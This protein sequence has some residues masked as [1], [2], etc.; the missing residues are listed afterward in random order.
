MFKKLTVVLCLLFSAAL[1]HAQMTDEAIMTYA[2]QELAAGKSQNQIARDLLAKGV[3][4]AQITRVINNYKAAQA[5]GTLPVTPASL[6]TDRPSRLEPAQE[7]AAPVIASP[8]DVSSAVTDVLPIYGHDIFSSRTMTF[9]PNANMATPENYVLGPGD[10]VIVDVWGANEATIRQT[11]SPEGTIIISQVGP[12]QLNGLTVVEA[13]ARVKSALGRKYSSLGS[14]LSHLTFSLGQNRSIQV[15]VMGEVNVPGTYRVSSFSTVFNAIYTAGGVAE[16]GSLRNVKLSRGGKVVAIVDMYSYIFDGETSSDVSLRDGDVIIVPAYSNVVSIT[17]KVRRP[18]RYELAEGESLDRLVELAGGFA[19]DAYRDD[20]RVI[21]QTGGEQQVLSVSFDKASSFMMSDCDAVEVGSAL[22]KYS[23]KLEIKGSVNR[24]GVYQLGDD[25]RTV[26]QLVAR[27]GGLTEDAFTGRAQIVREKDDLSLEVIAIALQGIVDGTVSDVLLKKNDVLY[28]ANKNDMDDKGDFTISGYVA[29]PGN[30][31][32]A[33]NT[34]VEDLILLAGGLVNGA[35]AVRVDVSRRINDPNSM[36]PSET[37]A[38]VFTFSI[39]D[40]LLPDGTPDF[41]LE[42]YDVVA[43]RRS[44]GY[45]EQRNVLLSGE[46]VF[47]GLYTI[48]NNAETVSQLIGRAGGPTSKAYLRGAVIRRRISEY[49]R[50]VRDVTKNLHSGLSVADSIE[51]AKADSIGYY[52]VG[53]ELDKAVA[54]PGSDYDVVLREGDEIII[55]EVTST[56]SVNGDVLYPNTVNFVSKK[57]IGYY[58]NEAGGFGPHAKK[59]KVYVVYMNGTVSSGRGSRPEPG[60]EIV[61]PTRP[62]R[63]GVTTSEAVSI[64]SSTVSLAA[65]ILSMLRILK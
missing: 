4:T 46:V 39:K 58:I 12:V 26:S 50:T 33:D 8:E 63:R 31:A 28:V 9:A 3:S 32:Y 60:C 45:V 53:V 22:E 25:I 13:R 62:E 40:G 38:K 14:G 16:T 15:N 34:T 18:M 44:P 48:V 65:I 49:E 35:S 19:G 7:N 23:N 30:Y 47:P 29:N 17:G 5:N 41:I 52:T 37:L 10:E 56:V 51:I 59:S 43:V 42:P 54:N 11:I 1:M 24:P 61:V 64:G 2:A 21:R 20:I 6:D 57:P 27:A 55:P 36:T